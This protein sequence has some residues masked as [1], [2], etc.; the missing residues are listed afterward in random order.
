MV[1]AYGV[2]PDGIGLDPADL[3]LG[4]YFARHR[5]QASR[6]LDTAHA[7]AIG[8]GDDI[9]GLMRTMRTAGATARDI[10]AVA[11]AAVRSAQ[12]RMG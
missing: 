10:E 9:D 11:L 4:L 7:S 3:W 6:A 1:A 8:R 2:V 12:P 5:V